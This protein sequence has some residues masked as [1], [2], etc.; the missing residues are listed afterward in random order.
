M[1]PFAS[2]GQYAARYGDVQDEVALAECLLDATR[3][4]CAEL[5]ADGIVWDESDEDYCERLSQVC[6]QVAHRA[7][8][9]SQTD[10]RIPIGATQYM[11][12]AGP[13]TE[14]FMLKNPYG[15][16]YLEQAERRLLGIGKPRIGWAVLG[17]TK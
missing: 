8:S 12:V 2:V 9:A 4:I 1:K 13:Y 17:S 6:R 10:E 16:V 5:E 11:Q 3:E 14:Q 15:Q 7:M